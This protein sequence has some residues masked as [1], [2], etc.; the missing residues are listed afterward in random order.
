MPI[1]AI[2]NIAIRIGLIGAEEAARKMDRFGG[3][4]DTAVAKIKNATAPA[5]RSLLAVNV[6][7]EQLRY[8]MENLSTGAGTL[9]LSLSRLGPVGL[10]A[11]AI[12]GSLGLAAAG[13]IREF[14]EA[15]QAT[16]L[17]TA[18]LQT[19]GNVAGVTV[20]E[21]QQLGEAVEE[22]TLFKKEEILKAGA[23][24]TSYGN[25]QEDVF[26]RAL[27][28][29]T[30]LATRLGG[31][32]AS[33]ADLLGAALENPEKGLGRLDRK[34]QDL[35][36]AQKEAIANFI[37][38][39][40]V[41]SAQAVILSHLEEKTRTLAESQA[42]GLT[43]AANRL[44]DAWDNLLESFGNS[45]NES[46]ALQASLSGLTFII[47]KLNKAVDNS[48]LAQKKRLEEEINDLE[49]SFGV[50]LDQAI[51]GSAPGLDAKK[52]QLAEI[53]RK[54]AEEAKKD[55]DEKAEALKAADEKRAKDRNEALL[56]I[57]KDYQ[58]KYKDAALSEREKLIEE[59]KQ[60]KERIDAL[61]RD[62][63][64]SD[65]AKKANTAVDANLKAQLAKLD[66]PAIEQR[67]QQNDAARKRAIEEINRGIL[68]TKPSFDV[69][70]QALDDWKAKLIEDLGGASAENQKYIDL[71]EQIYNVKLKDIYYKSL[72]DS[73]KWEDGAA[74]ALKRYAD[75]ATDAAKN[76]ERVF[77]NAAQK[78][79]DSLV[80]ALSSG[81]FSLKKLGDLI[82]DI[83]KDI[84][85]SFI[86]QNIT[87]PIADGL[88]SILGGGSGGS[89]GG[90]GGI[91]GNLFSSLFGSSSGGSSGGG[92][93]SGIG[94]FFSS[95]FHEGGV[96]GETLA[97]RRA[98]PAHAF[99]GARRFHNGL[100]PDEFPA[101]LQKGETV[102]P[103]NTRMGGNN[104]V[105]NITTP[106]AQS[107]MDSRG[108][109]MAKFAGEMQRS[110][111]RNS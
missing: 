87:G 12:L 17:L 50:R 34:F 10:A 53:N 78:I 77:T 103:K 67:A 32:V 106:N 64:N 66:R 44:S 68:Q 61:F 37:K 35:D 40:D 21:I 73:K 104:I 55:A 102:L 89:S 75:E 63:R 33:A 20:K 36:E 18:A 45:I 83:E 29:S 8:G 94:S 99:I 27:V 111:T 38:V 109:I 90:G 100:M 19:T 28:L 88:G 7:T 9:G 105:F 6:V 72:L 59:A 41:A 39:G 24:L 91:F 43:G 11:A 81:E 13:A 76:S 85:R 82:Q 30:D 101:I 60:A 96:V 71:I 22:T 110:R 97:G 25:I 2:Q 80:D 108:Q 23:A 58:K 79:E 93:F 14:K 107:F 74:R 15:E 62:D 48:P 70:K 49:G 42:Q 65:A 46:S 92:F 54:L 98:V 86:R 5:S 56:V 51:L 1:A 26:K 69:A 95:L 84:L 52:R 4:F 3:S 47:E 16:N 31:D 57:E